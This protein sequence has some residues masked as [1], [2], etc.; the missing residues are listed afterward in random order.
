MRVFVCLHWCVCVRVCV[1]VCVCVSVRARIHTVCDFLRDTG[2]VSDAAMLG[3]LGNHKGWCEMH[4]ATTWLVS[5]RH[6]SRHADVSPWRCWGIMIT[7]VYG[8]LKV[9][10]TVMITILLVMKSN[11][12][13]GQAG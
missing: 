3:T 13:F 1:C 5:A 7:K 12:Y 2:S 11:Y 9:I 4:N 6:L 8:L 10:I